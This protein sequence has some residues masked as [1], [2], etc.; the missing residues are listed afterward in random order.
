MKR[1]HEQRS[2]HL[3]LLA[4]HAEKLINE[5]ERYLTILN[6]V[7]QTA[8]LFGLLGTVTGM[9]KLFMSIES[10]S[11]AGLP[12]TPSSLA[13]GIW[14]ALITTAAGLIVG[15][16]ALIAFVLFNRLV[17]RFAGEVDAFLSEIAHR[18]SLL[19]WEVV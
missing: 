14:E 1:A 10:Q 11:L 15:I 5:V 7:A 13:G 8:P 9:I 12:I 19:G 18:A 3:S 2:L 4:V 6:V 16:P 17:D